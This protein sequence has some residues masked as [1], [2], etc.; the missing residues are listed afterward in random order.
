MGFFRGYVRQTVAGNLSILAAVPKM[1][2][3]ATLPKR[4]HP[5]LDPFRTANRLKGP[6]AQ[7]CWLKSQRYVR[8]RR[9]LEI[10]ADEFGVA[11]VQVRDEE[12]SHPKDDESDIAV[13]AV[14]APSVEKA[15]FGDAD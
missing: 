6:A 3:R 10:A 7:E 13:G 4:A 12:K 9:N 2:L 1:I 5:A 8:E 14:E 11:R 15:D